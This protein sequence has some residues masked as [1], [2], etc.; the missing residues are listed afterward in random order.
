MSEWDYINNYAICDPDK[1]VIGMKRK[2]GGYVRIILP[3]YTQCLPL[4][5]YC[6]QRGTKN[7][8]PIAM[9]CVGRKDISYKLCRHQMKYIL[10]NACII[11]YAL[12]GN[13]E[14]YF[15]NFM[16]E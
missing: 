8:V 1:S 7:L 2:S 11:L 3:T 15:F 9:D 10:S 14:F 4:S 13:V 5:V 16:S 6:M 12:A